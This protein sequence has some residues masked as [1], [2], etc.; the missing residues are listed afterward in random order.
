MADIVAGLSLHRLERIT[1]WVE[2]DYVGPGKIAGCQVLVARS[3]ETVYQRTFGFMDRERARPWTQDTLVRIYSMTKPIVSVALMMLWER[4]LFELD[5]PVMRILPEWAD[6]RVWVSGEGDAMVTKAPASPVTFRQILSHTAGLTYGTLLETVGVSAARHPVDEAYAQL[7]VRRDPAEDL[8]AFVAKL[9]RAPLRY[10]PGSRWMYSLAT[11]V[12][13]ALIERLSG[14]SLDKFLRQEIFEP[15]GMGDTAFHVDSSKADRFAA[16]YAR[17]S[18]TVLA[19]QD[20]P[21]TSP[22]LP[23]PTFLSGGGG[24]VSTMSDYHRFCEMLRGGGRLDRARVGGPRTIAMMAR[25]HLPGAAFLANIA[26]DGFSET[27]PDGVG[28]GLG[29]AVTVDGLAAGSPSEG[30]YSWGGAASTFFWV[31]PQENL[32][33]ILLAQLLPSSSHNMRGQLKKLVYAAF[34]N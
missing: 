26:L 7:K 17:R 19:L 18:D 11:D 3:G 4:G 8:D 27:T 33:C 23:A 28:F 10:D 6:Q 29:F 20:D 13:G 32:I 14:Q 16:C 2:D 34:E 15:L 12:A 25:N 1:R 9:G 22:F 24:L 21:L 31:D 5:E 30:D